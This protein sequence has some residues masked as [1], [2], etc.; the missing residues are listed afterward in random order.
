MRVLAQRSALLHYLVVSV[1]LLFWLVP[2]LLW[3]SNTIVATQAPLSLNSGPGIVTVNGRQLIVSK[4]N[5]DGTLSSPNPYIIRGVAWSPATVETTDN[6]NSRRAAFTSQATTDASLIAAMNANTVRTY[7]E[8]PLDAS[9]LMVLDQL[10]SQ[11][12]MVILTVDGATNDVSRIQ[13]TV[14]FYKITP[15][16]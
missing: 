3:Q 11:G 2:A 8:P 16:F 6:N 4:R 9:G 15:L 1:F 5:L 14:N 12:I 13:Q 10:Y 7:L